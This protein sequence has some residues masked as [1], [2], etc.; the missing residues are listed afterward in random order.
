MP[1]GGWRASWIQNI[2]SKLLDVVRVDRDL[3][4]HGDQSQSVDGD[5]TQSRRTPGVNPHGEMQW[6]G[7]VLTGQE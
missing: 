7:L 5:K 4:R 1:P 6:S 3:D 2:W